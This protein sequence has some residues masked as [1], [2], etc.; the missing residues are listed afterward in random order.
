MDLII[1]PECQKENLGTSE[2]CVY[3]GHSFH[4]KEETVHPPKITHTWRCPTCGNMISQEPCP[5]CAGNVSHPQTAVNEPAQAQKESNKKPMPIIQK[6]LACTAILICG[7][8]IVFAWSAI[9][10]NDKKD[11]KTNTLDPNRTHESCSYYGETRVF[12]WEHQSMYNC[13]PDGDGYYY[14][15]FGHHHHK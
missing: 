8:V 13:I 6:I 14:I 1:C 5:Y 4:K 10:N 11:T 15:T 2:K 7:I 12:G 3:C 9:T